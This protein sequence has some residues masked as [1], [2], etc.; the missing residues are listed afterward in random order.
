MA[1]GKGG[2]VAGRAEMMVWE[3][4]LPRKKKRREGDSRLCKDNYVLT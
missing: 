2:G 3:D 1:L 4:K